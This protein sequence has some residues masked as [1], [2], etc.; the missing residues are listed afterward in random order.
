MNIKW[1]GGVWYWN[2]P[3]SHASRLACSQ[4]GGGLFEAR[5]CVCSQLWLYDKEERGLTGEADRLYICS[6]CLSLIQFNLNWHENTNMKHEGT[7]SLTFCLVSLC[8]LAFC[9]SVPGQCCVRVVKYLSPLSLIVPWAEFE[10]EHH[11]TQ[12]NRRKSIFPPQE[13]P[14]FDFWQVFASFNFHQDKPSVRKIALSIFPQVPSVASIPAS[15]FSLSFQIFTSFWNNT[16]ANKQYW[17]RFWWTI[18][19]SS[20]ANS[21]QATIWLI[22]WLKHKMGDLIKMKG[23]S[24]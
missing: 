10:Q 1:A 9:A 20:V 21:W 24:N 17:V 18:Y 16:S 15:Y 3:Q 7:F 14:F 4:R 19:R 23:W 12:V 2:S 6:L 22:I 5:L 13:F 8:M 11:Q